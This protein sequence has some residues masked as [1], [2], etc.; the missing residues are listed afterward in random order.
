MLELRDYQIKALNDLFGFFERERG[1]PLVVLPTGAG[2]SLVNAEWIRGV[3]TLDPRARVLCLT[4]VRELVAQNYAELMGLWPDA[5]AGIYSAGLGRRDLHARILFASIQSIHRKA[6]QVQQCDM[7]IVDEAHLV[8]RNAETMYGR[9][10]AELLAINPAM[11][12]IGLTATPFRLDS[13]QLNEGEGRVFTALAHETPVRELIDKGYLVPL[14][15]KAGHGEI[16]TDGVHTRGGEF[17][18]AE[19]NDRAMDPDTIRA[20]ADD[21]VERSQGRRGWLVFG[22]SIEHCEALRE[23]LLDRTI[24]ACVISADTPS[25]ERD[26]IIARYKAMEITA[27]VS[28]GVLTT[29]FNAKHV[30]LIALARPTKSTGLYIQMVGRGTRCIGADIRESVANGKADCLVLDYGGNIRR[31][32]PF[33]EPFLPHTR[34]PKAADEE[35]GDAPTKT[36]PECEEVVLIAAASCPACGFEFPP[37]ESKVAKQA[38]AAP[39][40]AP[41]P[42]W[43]EVDQVQYAIHDG[44]DG[45]PDTLKV[46]YRTGMT[47]HHEW[48]CF[49]H[50]PGSYARRMA[51]LWWKKRDLRGTD[52]V[53]PTTDAAETWTR[54]GGLATPSAIRVRVEGK[55]TQ[56]T[57]HRIDD[58]RLPYLRTISE[59]VRVPA[60]A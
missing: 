17:V 7:V 52:H 44:R 12:I 53:P 37:R 13:G 14:R 39:I 3:F 28:M 45:K 10:L 59:G 34:A 22:C 41:P 5:P 40:L 2:K 8:P 31:H 58:A 35:P 57:D 11:K 23:A 21:I 42:A 4:H 54:A 55:Y 32:G 18:P 36:C 60:P 16:T 33:D 27:L 1:N 24:T 38:D 46:T 47:F 15:S 56:V 29:G 20:I 51:E 48:V 49:D 26:I 6:L 19:L 43:L 50:A 9:F 30:D 25:D